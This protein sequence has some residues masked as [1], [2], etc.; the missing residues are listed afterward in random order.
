MSGVAAAAAIA[1]EPVIK[2]FEIAITGDDVSDLMAGI[3]KVCD[4]SGLTARQVQFVFECYAKLYKDTA[5][6]HE[7]A[8]AD[9]RDKCGS[10]PPRGTTTS[11]GTAAHL[12]DGYAGTGADMDPF[13]RALKDCVMP[14]TP[15][16][17]SEPEYRKLRELMRTEANLGAQ[18]GTHSPS[19]NRP[20]SIGAKSLFDAPDDKSPPDFSGPG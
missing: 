18:S 1:Q 6:G 2:R 15:S 11:S 16:G 5:D 4:E 9:W 7:R 17:L 13:Y 3:R 12:L 8:L 20:D 14:G 19:T 10:P